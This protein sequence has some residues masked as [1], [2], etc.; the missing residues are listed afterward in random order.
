MHWGVFCLFAGI[1]GMGL[2]LCW[3]VFVYCVVYSL[4]FRCLIVLLFVG[5]L[6]ICCLFVVTC[7]C[8]LD[9]WAV[10]IRVVLLIR[11]VLVGL[12]VVWLLLAWFLWYL[13]VGHGCVW[14]VCDWLWFL[15][16]LF[17]LIVMFGSIWLVWWCCGGYCLRSC[18]LCNSVVAV[19]I[20][21][22]LLF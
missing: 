1:P 2:L 8:W 21:S 9:C 7:C 22:Y 5:L 15:D 16:W 4:W 18:C 6:V 19:R 20:Y 3:M 12:F 14:L 11:S 17:V 10:F 13:V